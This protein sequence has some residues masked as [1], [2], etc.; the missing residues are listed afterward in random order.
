MIDIGGHGDLQK[1]GFFEKEATGDLTYR[2]TGGCLDERGNATGSIYIPAAA[3][4]AMLRIR[5]TAHGRPETARP[6]RVRVLF[7]E[8]EL[9]DFT[10]DGTWRDFEIALPDP[11]PKGSKILRLEVPAWRPSN[12]DKLATDTRDLGIM[13]DL[14]EVLPR[15]PKP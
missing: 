7:S 4:G 10:A 3:A 14:V 12:T 5:A 11:L 6:P 13:V 8:V 9:G 1:S 15:A 2:W